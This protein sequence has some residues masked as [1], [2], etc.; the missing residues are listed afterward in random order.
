MAPPA[1]SFKTCRAPDG[2]LTAPGQ[3]YCE[4][5]AH[6]SYSLLDGVP[7][8]EELAEQAAGLGLPAIALTDHDNLY[9]LVPFFTR[10]QALQVKPIIGA[11]IT[12]EDDSHLTLLA[13]TQPGYHSL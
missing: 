4:L 11:E 12:L 10:A 3:L 9:G 6:S 7:R 13:E 8:P 2:F 1:R 5:H